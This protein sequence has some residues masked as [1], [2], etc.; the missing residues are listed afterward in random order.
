MK[1]FFSWKI[2][3]W[4]VLRL[5]VF[6]VLVGPYLTALLPGGGS[7]EQAWL[8]KVIVRVEEMRDDCDDPEVRE[9]LAY[10]ARR[11]RNIGPFNVQVRSCG[12]GMAGL[13]VPYCPGV[14]LDPEIAKNVDPGAVTLVHEAQHDYF[15]YFG[16]SHF[17]IFKG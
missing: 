9:I 2:R 7:A 6:I 8:D 5:V 12:P 10:T 13:N 3:W 11:Y 17:K 15:P 4:R 16:H 1:D 14:T